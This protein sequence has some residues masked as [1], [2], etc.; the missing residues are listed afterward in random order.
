MYNNSSIYFQ[1]KSGPIETTEKVEI[2]KKGKR[3]KKKKTDKKPARV[4]E[5]EQILSKGGKE[6]LLYMVLQLLKDKKPKEKK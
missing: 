1:D 2:V 5:L 6:G 4:K 3:K